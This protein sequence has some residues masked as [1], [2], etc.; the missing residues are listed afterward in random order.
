MLLGACSTKPQLPPLPEGVQTLTGTVVPAVISVGRRG[1]HLLRGVSTDLALLE[2]ASINLREF[3]GRTTALR[4][5]YERN[6]D[7]EDLPI[8]I[9]QSVVSS[10]E[11]TRTW[12]S[13]ALGV[14]ASIPRSWGMSGTGVSI[15]FVPAGSLRPVVALTMHQEEV[16]P[17]GVMLTIAGGKAIRFLDD[18]SGE[19]RIAIE[20]SSGYLEIA[21]T[22]QGSTDPEA[23]RAEWLAFLRSLKIRD[24]LQQSS[25]ASSDAMS[26]RSIRDDQPC[27]GL[28]GIL[29]PRGQ[30]CEIT[31]LEQ[32]IGVCRSID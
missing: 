25:G 13:S 7:P 9:V 20:R 32:N 30:Y 27:G 16:F 14:T 15:A 4:G 12:S 23:L 21:F 3:Q 24:I 29:C 11:E 28:A 26:P 1:S 31:D 10:E 2:S 22:P 17:S 19:Q 18:I 5:R 6:I 8:F